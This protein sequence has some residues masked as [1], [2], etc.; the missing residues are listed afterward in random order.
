MNKLSVETSSMPSAASAHPRDRFA[1][2]G[3]EVAVAL[4][5]DTLLVDGP[6]SGR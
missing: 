3:T 5:A 4:I 6:V 2:A 1:V